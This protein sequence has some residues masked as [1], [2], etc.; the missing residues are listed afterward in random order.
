LEVVNPMSVAIR[1]LSAAGAVALTLGILTQ[2]AGSAAQTSGHERA[3]GTQPHQRVA[4]LAKPAKHFNELMRKA[5]QRVERQ[6]AARE[7]AAREAKSRDGGSTSTAGGF[8]S[9]ES[10][11]VSSSTLQA[12]AACESGGDPTA[13]SADGTYHGLYQ[14]DTGTWASVGGSGDPA[15]ASP[16]EQTY[17]AA[18]LYSRSGSNP[19]PICGS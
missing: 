18:L 15:A 7:A 1:G 14:F 13:V 11:G 5:H 12:I 8:P 4:V 2:P 19:W 6:Q 17:R 9:P 10:V 3:S 16:A